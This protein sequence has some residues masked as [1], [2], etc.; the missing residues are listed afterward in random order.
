MHNMYTMY[1]YM[2]ICI[3]MY[4]CIYIYIYIF[5]Y[6]YCY[7]YHIYIYISISLSLS[8]YIYIYIYTHIPVRRRAK[9]NPR[10]AAILQMAPNMHRR[11]HELTSGYPSQDQSYSFVLLVLRGGISRSM[12]ELPR[13]LDSDILTLWIL[14]LW[15]DR[16]SG[17]DRRSHTY[18]QHSQQNEPLG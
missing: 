3:C 6:Y 9:A 16:R 4:V 18:A 13:N 2:Y 15:I 5:T 7:Y 14:S 1:M 8:I 12:G 17:C 11:A 10:T